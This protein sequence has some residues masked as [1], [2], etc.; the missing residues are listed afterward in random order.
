VGRGSVV[1][2]SGPGGT[3]VAVPFVAIDPVGAVATELGAAVPAVGSLAGTVGPSPGSAVAAG[4]LPAAGCSTGGPRPDSVP[5][6]ADEGREALHPTRAAAAAAAAI[7]GATRRRRRRCMRSIM[8]AGRPPRPSPDR[9]RR[10]AD[11][12]PSVAEFD[13]ERVA[14]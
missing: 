8:V 11:A 14:Q 2:D 3:V 5:G 1:V 6:V 7:K 4:S 12:D 10:R 13:V 9:R